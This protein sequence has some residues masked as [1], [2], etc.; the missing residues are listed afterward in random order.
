[1]KREYFRGGEASRPCH[2]WGSE[3][4]GR[5]IARLFGADLRAR[6][7]VVDDWLTQ[8]VP[9]ARADRYRKVAV[10]YSDFAGACISPFL[11]GFYRR[12]AEDYLARAEAA[13]RVAETDARRDKT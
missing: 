4:T 6:E 1:V 11:R 8:E 3:G 12:I 2:R 7:R 13:L 9:L 10:Q 5:E